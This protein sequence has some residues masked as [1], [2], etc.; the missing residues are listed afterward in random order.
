MLIE[1]PKRLKHLGYLIEFNTWTI[2]A[3]P[4][5][6][7]PFTSL[8]IDSYQGAPVLAGVVENVANDLDYPAPIGLDSCYPVSNNRDTRRE[9]AGHHQQH[10]AHYID[11]TKLLDLQT[12]M[13][14]INSKESQEVV[15]ESCNVVGLV[16]D[17]ANHFI[18]LFA[19][20][21][22]EVPVQY[23]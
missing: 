5:N 4:D 14:R 10:L 3:D 7:A 6:D 12:Q 19:G 16:R 2:V 9:C 17:C 1:L 8:Y 22:G 20:K 13:S 23:L 18:D 15:N 11:D 21:L